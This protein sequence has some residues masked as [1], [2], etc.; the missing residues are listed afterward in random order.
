VV[1][2]WLY[3]HSWIVTGALFGWQDGAQALRILIRVD[4][5]LQRRWDIGARSEAK[6]RR[7]LAEVNRHLK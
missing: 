3:Q 2:H 6:A 7:A 1:N 5:S 4:K